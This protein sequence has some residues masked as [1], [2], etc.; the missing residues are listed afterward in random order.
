MASYSTIDYHG[1][2]VLTP[3]ASGPGGLVLFNALKELSERTG[4]FHSHAGAPGADDDNQDTGG[5]GACFINTFWLDTSTNTW[6]VC[7]SAAEGAA[8]WSM[9]TDPQVL[10]LGGY[11]FLSAPAQQSLLL[12]REVCGAGL[13]TSETQIIMGY[14]AGYSAIAGGS[15]VIIGNKACFGMGDPLYVVVIGQEAGYQVNCTDY[16]VIIGTMAGYGMG[17]GNNT[18]RY[19]V[20]IGYGA[21]M[22]VGGAGNAERNVYIGKSC[23]AGDAAG[24]SGDDNVAIGSGAFG[25][26]ATGNQNVIAGVESGKS[27]VSGSG[28]VFVGFN[29]GLN[30][31]GSNKL[32]IENSDSGTPLI[33]GEFD[34]RVILLDAWFGLR[35]KS[36]DPSE[37]AD[38]QC[39]I[40][41]SD[42]TQKGDDGDVLIAAKAGG[43]TKW[44]TLFD[45]SA[46]SA[47]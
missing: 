13:L 34:N 2:D 29:A 20:L 43:V 17:V 11:A 33:Y 24:N 42:G 39:V 1:I 36:A 40:W 9:I 25:S 30:E 23:G 22:N 19:S 35:E 27:L 16:S 21:G 46:G 28:N 15:S 26:N 45:H 12:G 18:C 10:Y 8:T 38:G 32:Y 41:M 14:R 47:W 5:N 3:E 44:T 6:Y 4:P 31:T 37:P 7:T